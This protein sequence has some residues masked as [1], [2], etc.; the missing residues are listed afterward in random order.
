MVE[1]VYPSDSPAPDLQPR[2]MAVTAAMRDLEAAGLVVDQRPRAAEMLPVVD[3]NGLV[4]GQASREY[5]HSGSKLLHP[6]VHLHILNRRGELYI[7]KRSMKKDLLPGRWDT[8]VGGHVGYGESIREALY[9]EAGEE[10][11]FY[12]FNPIALESYVFES[13]IEL[14]LVNI[15][16]AVGNFELHPDLDEVSEGRFWSFDEIDANLSKSIFTPNFEKEFQM[17]RRPL[18]ALL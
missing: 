17:V 9:R 14:E 13:D 7:Q 12:D 18:E 5:C 15:F 16:A 3:K 1:L 10:L 2:P 11:G 8:A 4:I 6:V